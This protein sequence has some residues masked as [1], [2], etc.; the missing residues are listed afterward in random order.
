[1]G[2]AGL[3]TLMKLWG[4]DTPEKREACLKGFNALTEQNIARRGLRIIG[5]KPEAGQQG[6]FYVRIPDSPL[7]IR[8][9]EGGMGPYGQ[10]CLDFYDTERDASVNLP[11]GYSL[12]PA[13]VPAPLG[14][15]PGYPPPGFPMA[16][17]APASMAGS[18]RS[19][20][21]NMGMR[22]IPEG[23][24]KWMVPQ[25]AYITLRRDGHEDVIFQIPTQQPAF[26]ALP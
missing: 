7:A 18:L 19:W 25:G 22:E 20:E 5:V 1:M 15:G 2:E 8:M 17:N 9:W 24:E 11:Q 26:V 14:L 13:A 21:R 10:F 3:N 12:H 6:V 23:E 4:A 16:L